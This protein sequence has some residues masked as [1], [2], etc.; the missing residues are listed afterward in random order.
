MENNSTMDQNI[1]LLNSAYSIPVK[2][3]QDLS[4]K[5]MMEHFCSTSF[6]AKELIEPDN[7]AT[8]MLPSFFVYRRIPKG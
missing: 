1:E 4:F 6:L 3:D 7:A 2:E 8:L 5:T